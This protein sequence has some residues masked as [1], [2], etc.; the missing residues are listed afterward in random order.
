MSKKHKQADEEAKVSLSYVRRLTLDEF[1]ETGLFPSI[2]LK[3]EASNNHSKTGTALD[4]PNMLVSS[5]I[6]FNWCP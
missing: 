3:N 4:F 6:H 1:E 5:V 2:W